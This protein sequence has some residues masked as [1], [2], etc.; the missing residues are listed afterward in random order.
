VPAVVRPGL[1][2]H[3]C[4]T[5]LWATN[6]SDPEHL[7]LGFMTGEPSRY[8]DGKNTR[9]NLVAFSTHDDRLIG[10]SPITREQFVRVRELFDYGD[11]Q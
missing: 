3:G 9:W 5:A 7:R 8:D 10:R 1:R 11:D 6:H 4:G 2:R